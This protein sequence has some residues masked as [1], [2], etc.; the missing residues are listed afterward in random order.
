MTEHS[1]DELKRQVDAAFSKSQEANS[2]LSAAKKRLLDAKLQETGLLGHIVSYTR[3][4][5]ERRF[6]VE[7]FSRWSDRRL[8][9]PQIKKD[10]TLSQRK[11]DAE[12]TR[13]T[14]LGLY[15]SP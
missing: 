3:G 5:E 15:E 13:L 2:A 10:G 12:L 1:L 7:G 8:S 9:G 14:D 6:V 4:K 11:D